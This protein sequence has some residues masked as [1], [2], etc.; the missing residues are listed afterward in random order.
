MKL[1]VKPVERIDPHRVKECYLVGYDSQGVEVAR[2]MYESK[3]L[4]KK[5][6]K[7]FTWFWKEQQGK[8][9]Q[10]VKIEEA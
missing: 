9:I 6:R 1:A 3:T 8:D 7:N 2:G 10:L 4:A 5:Q